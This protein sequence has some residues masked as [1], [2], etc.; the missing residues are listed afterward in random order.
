MLRDLSPN[1]TAPHRKV[2][3]RVSVPV[4]LVYSKASVPCKG[5]K[6]STCLWRQVPILETEEMVMRVVPV[7]IRARM[8][9]SA[10]RELSVFVIIESYC[11]IGESDT[12]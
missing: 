3:A 10:K 2:F 8:Y 11:Y 12:V 5:V 4:L 7:C 6:L 9:S 1:P